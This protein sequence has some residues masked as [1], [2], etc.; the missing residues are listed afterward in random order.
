MPDVPNGVFRVTDPDHRQKLSDLEARIEAAK[1]AKTPKN[2][3]EEHYSIAQQGWRMVLE[4]VSGLMIGF[5]LGYGMDIL[6][7]TLPIFLVLMTLLGFIA[8]VKTMMH[9]A[10]E[11]H[12]NNTADNPAED[13]ERT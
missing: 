3:K 12:K 10:T 6:F 5:G 1:A 7:G 4:L 9:T 13:D 11:F 2:H 8:G